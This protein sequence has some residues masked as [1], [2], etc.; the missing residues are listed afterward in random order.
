MRTLVKLIAAVTLMAAATMA[1]AVRPIYNVVDEP[2]VTATG[3]PPTEEQVKAA[4]MRAGAVLGWKVGEASPGLLV[5]TLDLRKHQ[6]VVQIPYS[7][8]KYSI[9]YKSSINLDEK[10]GQIHRNYNSWI[11]NLTKGINGQLMSAN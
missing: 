6:A 1:F 4:I 9:T 3:K 8:A 10:D 5:A 11:Q 2:V 7:T